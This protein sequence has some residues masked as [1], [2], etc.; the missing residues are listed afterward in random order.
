MAIK[1]QNLKQKISRTRPKGYAYPIGLSYQKTDSIEEPNN[2][3][4]QTNATLTSYPTPGGDKI[5]L[6]WTSTGTFEQNSSY[7]MTGCDLL[8][9]AGGGGGWPQGPGGGGQ[10]GGGAGGLIYYSDS[11]GDAPPSPVYSS[12]TKTANGS[13]VGI[14]ANVNYAVTV[15]GGGGGNAPG[16]NSSWINVSASVASPYHLSFTAVGG[17]GGRGAPGGSGAGAYGTPVGLG[18]AGQGN[19]GAPAVGG[20]GY[21]GGGGGGAGGAGSVWADVSAMSG[22]DGN[23]APAINKRSSGGNGLDFSI[24]G[25]QRTYAAGGGGS[26]RGTFGYGG[27]DGLGGSGLNAPA[28]YPRNATANRGSG[29]GGGPAP[30]VGSGSGGVVILSIPKGGSDYRIN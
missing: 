16:S 30:N 27:S 26:G 18:T 25:T 14:A 9:V 6:T 10:A 28:P 29:G 4:T 17:G 20:A 19:D 12:N 7:T 24:S 13:A 15:G 23:P 1:F 3:I 11:P 22:K 5:A 21:I 8:I 2:F